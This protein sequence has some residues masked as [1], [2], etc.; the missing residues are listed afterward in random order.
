MPHHTKPERDLFEWH[1]AN[2]LQQT[3]FP[4]YTVNRVRDVLKELRDGAN[5][6]PK[7]PRLQG[8]WD[9]WLIAKERHLQ[10][11]AAAL[12]FTTAA[13]RVTPA[14][15]LTKFKLAIEDKQPDG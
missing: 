13:K 5:Y 6:S 9:G 11:T 7:Y 1:A 4:N 2:A 8:M 3:M 14:A 10:F 15:A 12:E